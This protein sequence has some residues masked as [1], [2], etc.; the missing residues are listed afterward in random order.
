MRGRTAGQHG[1]LPIK[2][3]DKGIF[4]QKQTKITKHFVGRSQ[5]EA[6]ERFW[7][8]ERFLSLGPG[9]ASFTRFMVVN[10]IRNKQAPRLGT[11][12]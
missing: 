12:V 7:Q 5:A 9:N 2:N 4:V 3:W 6:G 10:G 8:V 1:V 11:E